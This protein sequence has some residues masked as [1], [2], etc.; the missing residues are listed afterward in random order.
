MK[1][2]PE[3]KENGPSTLN[4]S[5]STTTSSLTASTDASGTCSSVPSPQL[6]EKQDF[7]AMRLKPWLQEQSEIPFQVYAQPSRS[8]DALTHPKTKTFNL[9]SFYNDSINRMPTTTQNRSSKSHSYVC[10]CQDFETREQRIA[11]AIG[12][13][14]TVATFFVMQSC[15]YLKV[16]QAKKQQTDSLCL[17]NLQ[18]F[19]DRKLIEHNN[20][21]LK[22]S[23]CIYITFEMQKKDEKNNT[24][25]QKASGKVNMC[26][27]RMAASII[28]RIRSYEGTNNNTPSQPSGTST[29]STTSH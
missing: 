1:T 7:Q 26:P 14:T 21:H 9:A 19:R 5:G 20:P 29:K 6:S 16:T 18:F 12:Q 24:V 10:Y 17:C 13:L 8:T 23:D 15:E 25:T 11:A 4:P 28:P 22:F 27:V 2:K 3:L